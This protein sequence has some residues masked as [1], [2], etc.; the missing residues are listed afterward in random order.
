MGQQLGLS[1]VTAWRYL[2]HLLAQG[3]VQAETVG[4]SVGRPTKRYR[5]A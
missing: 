2:E 3:E 5:R 1:R 4:P